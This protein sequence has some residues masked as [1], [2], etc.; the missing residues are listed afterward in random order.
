MVIFQTWMLLSGA[1]LITSSN[2][3]KVKFELFSGNICQVQ[4]CILLEAMKHLHH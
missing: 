4:S 1:A 2:I 3:G